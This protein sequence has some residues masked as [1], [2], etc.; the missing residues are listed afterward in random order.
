MV[1]N[2]GP[3]WRLVK[4]CSLKGRQ[5]INESDLN[6][7][8]TSLSDTPNF[9]PR[10][11]ASVR[12]PSGTCFSRLINTPQNRTELLQILPGISKP[13]NGVSWESSDIPFLLLEGPTWPDD[14][15]SNGLTIELSMYVSPYL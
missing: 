4:P 5:R 1:T 12:R 14:N 10:I 8:A 3:D 7:S 15:W 13:V 11:W 6:I 9:K 2:D